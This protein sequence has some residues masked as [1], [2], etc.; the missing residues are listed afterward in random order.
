[1]RTF[2][3]AFVK[4]NNQLFIIFK[5]LNRILLFS[6]IRFMIYEQN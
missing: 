2:Y 4:K 3:A 6:L 5:F 1:M